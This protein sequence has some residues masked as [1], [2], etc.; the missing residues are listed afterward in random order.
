MSRTKFFRIFDYKLNTHIGYICY[1][2]DLKKKRTLIHSVKLCLKNLL[3][4]AIR[5]I[6]VFVF[7]L[8]L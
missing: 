7:P 1:P 2:E 4:E 3:S 6:N 5:T 8:F